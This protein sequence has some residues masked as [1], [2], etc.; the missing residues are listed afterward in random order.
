MTNQEFYGDALP[1][2]EMAEQFLLELVTAYPGYGDG[3]S[4]SRQIAAC[5]SRIKSA[6]SMM[7]K[8]ENRGFKV[9]RTAALKDVYD[10]VGIRIICNFFDDVYKVAEW[11]ETNEAIQILQKKDYIAFPKP[12]GYRSLHLCLKIRQG[13]AAGVQA[14]IQIR[15]MAIDFWA[16][17]EHQLKYKKEIAHEDLIRKELKRC[18]DEIA[19]TDISMQTIR[20]ML[21]TEQE[22]STDR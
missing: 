3:L 4:E 22:W 13:S 2:L 16:T 21:E 19:A 7:R 1:V 14:E 10:A 17:L 6:D 11:L 15:T 12:N 20:D 8:L 5:R 18:A 9:S